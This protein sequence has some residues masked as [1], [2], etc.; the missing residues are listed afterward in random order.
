VIQTVRA[1]RGTGLDGTRW[2][3]LH[4]RDRSYFELFNEAAPQFER[5]LEHAAAERDWTDAWVVAELTITPLGL[6]LARLVVGA[7]PAP[8]DEVNPG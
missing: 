8:W 2:V 4:N 1:K 7:E 6:Q 3:S 5:L